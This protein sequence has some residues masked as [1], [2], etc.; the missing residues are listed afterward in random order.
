MAPSATAAA[1][2][3]SVAG[4]SSPVVLRPGSTAVAALRR[5]RASVLVMFWVHRSSSMSVMYPCAGAELAGGDL[6]H[7]R[8]HFSVVGVELV[9]G[10][11]QGVQQFGVGCLPP[12]RHAP[13][14]T[15]TGVR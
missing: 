6:V 15:Q 12:F 13:D 11:G 8:E 4:S 14:S 2:A 10:G 1:V 9:L 7:D 3:G 5:R